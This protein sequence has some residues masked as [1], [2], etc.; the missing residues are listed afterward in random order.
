[1]VHLLRYCA[2]LM[3]CLSAV[4]CCGQ[5]SMIDTATINL[6]IGNWKGSLTYLDY[7]TN[8]PF[9]MPADLQIRRLANSNSQLVYSNFYPNEPDANDHDTVTIAQ[10]GAMINNEV[11]KVRSVLPNGDIQIITEYVGFDGND[12]KSAIIR[13]RY[14]IG[15]SNYTARKEVRFKDEA[16]W[17]KRSE[18][19]YSR[20]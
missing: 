14:I 20:Q 4:V 1:M 8:K 12:H 11:V 18:Y 7:K 9:T 17:I 15:K 16:E 3:C 10:G 19:S 5:T 13:H 6:L 2:S